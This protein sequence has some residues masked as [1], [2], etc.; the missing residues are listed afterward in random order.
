M[1]RLRKGRWAGEQDRLVQVC[2]DPAFLGVRCRLGGRGL[3]GP[4][5]WP[6][7]PRIYS[8]RHLAQSTSSLEKVPLSFESW[9]SGP[10]LP[11][12]PRHS[13]GWAWRPSIHPHHA[14][15]S[16]FKKINLFLVASALPCC[17][18]AFSSC[19]DWGLLS[20]CGGG[21]SPC[22]PRALQRAGSQLRCPGFLAPWDMGSS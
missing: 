1:S 8:Q 10:T 17:A 5:G 9:L 20:S 6:L 22:G 12:A 19:S 14:L 11:G 21:S 15:S 7:M 3:L 2:P 16:L 4:A 18:R 13:L